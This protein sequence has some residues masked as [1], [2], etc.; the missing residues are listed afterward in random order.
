[1]KFKRKHILLLLLKGL[2]RGK[3]DATCMNIE[4]VRGECMWIHVTILPVFLVELKVFKV[5]S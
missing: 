3:V 1:M 2:E 4:K 5:K